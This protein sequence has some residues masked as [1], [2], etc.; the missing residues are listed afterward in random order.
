MNNLK[1]ALWITLIL[2]CS[3]SI[4]V[5]QSKRTGYVPV[6]DSLQLYYEFFGQGKDTVIISDG[7]FISL[8]LKAYTG[9]LTLLTFDVRDRGKSS[10][11]NS[12]ASISIE[13]N[14]DDVEAIRKHFNLKKVN[15]LGFSYMGAMAAM[16]ASQYPTYVKS[17]V[18]M[19]PMS[20]S[21]K[22][23]SKLITKPTDFSPY[24]KALNE[25]VASGGKESNPAEYAR[26]YWKALLA[27]SLHD[28]NK[29]DAIVTRM[30]T[31]ENESPGNVRST[32]GA[33][34][35]KLGDWNFADVASKV[36]CRT[37]IIFGSSDTIPVENSLEWASSIPKSRYLEFKESGHLLFAEET[38]KWIRSLEMFFSGGWPNDSLE[39]MK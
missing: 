6:N 19:A 12:D 26:L 33:I 21:K 22:A 28:L 30:P 18:L 16:Y 1:P 38:E 25:F 29:L 3:V 34:F 35:K 32:V 11:L 24:R 5:G 37:L 20:I 36:E 7:Q 13:S 9:P 4:A 17:I 23:N 2:G 27:P 14:L 8:Y 39:S 10:A 15:L 31:L